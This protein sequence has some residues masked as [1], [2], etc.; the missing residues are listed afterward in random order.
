MTPTQSPVSPAQY[1]GAFNNV[2]SLGIDR[3]NYIALQ[4]DDP[5][6]A[7][8]FAE[9]NMGFCLT[10]VDSDGRH[11]L[12][13]HGRDP[14]SLVYTPGEQGVVDHISYVVRGADDLVAAKR[15]L[16]E[17]GVASEAVE[18]SKLWRHGPALRF[19]NPGGQTIEITTGV[20]VDVPMAALVAKPRTTPAPITFDHA[21][22]RARDVDA[23]FEFASRAMGLKESSRILTPDGL[24]FLGFFRSH[25]LY[26]CYA[27]SKSPHDGLNHI[28]FTLKDPLAIYDAAEQ[29]KARGKV[30]VL[31]G[32]LRHGPGHNIALYFLDYTGT[33]VEYSAEEEI[34][35]DDVGYAPRVWSV[36]ERGAMNEWDASMPPPEMM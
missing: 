1:S 22:V 27:V 24:P 21:V 15:T 4:A 7:A 16:D 6:A 23:G 25:T 28:Q 14:Y 18:Q 8:R 29:M 9:E 3:G 26:H 20:R 13:A 30:K 33:I 32:P 17:K 5:S 12:A 34:I 36:T 19:K 2:R 11:Y 10:H 31:W 35:L